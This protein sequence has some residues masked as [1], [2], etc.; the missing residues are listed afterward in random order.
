MRKAWLLGIALAGAVAPAADAANIEIFDR[1]GVTGSAAERTYRMAAAY[2][3]SVISSDVTIRFGAEYKSLGGGVLGAG[4]PT[5][6]AYTVRDWVSGI[7]A[8]RSGSALDQRAVLPTLTDDAAAFLISAPGP[9]GYSFDT[10]R[11][12]YDN[13]TTGYASLNNAYLSVSTALVRSIGGTAVYDP[14]D[15]NRLD[16]NIFFNSDSAASFD[17]DPTDGVAPGQYDFLNVVIHEMGH[18]L[19]FFSGVEYVDAYGSPN[20][21]NQGTQVDFSAYPLLTP[22]DMF[23]YSNDPTNIVP[24]NEP[25]LD[26]SAG[27]PAY[28]SIDGGN[29]AL[30]GNEFS[31]GVANGN[32]ESPSH[33]KARSDTNCIGAQGIMNPFACGADVTSLDLA[34]FD[35]MGYNL[36]VDALA[37]NGG[38]R[39]SSLQIATWYDSAVPEPATWAMMVLG[40]GI[41]GSALRTRR[42]T[43]SLA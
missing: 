5:T 23:R 28:F 3:G 9:G 21:G 35:A 12:V 36:S 17:F 2:W 20:G 41:V 13:D 24:G 34:A 18:A 6:M 37:N 15:T 38:Y 16:G 22:L 14:N 40:F 32:G 10:T 43:T 26:M 11:Q 31:T 4:A 30:F 39:R 8:T 42:R 7:N 25:L 19:G 33:W 29:S 1:G 27:A